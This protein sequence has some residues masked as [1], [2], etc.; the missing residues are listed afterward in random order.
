MAMLKTPK[1]NPLHDGK[2]GGFRSKCTPF[3][4][5]VETTQEAQ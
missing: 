4:Q 2:I 1:G 3:N 5:Q